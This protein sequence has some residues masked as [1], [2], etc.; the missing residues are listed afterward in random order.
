MDNELGQ[1]GF[2]YH[3]LDKVARVLE[4]ICEGIKAERVSIK[5]VTVC[6]LNY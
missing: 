2:F 5:I 1:Q 6:S 3:E 4:L